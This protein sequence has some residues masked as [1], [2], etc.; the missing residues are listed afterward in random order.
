MAKLVPQPQEAVAL[1]F[2][3]LKDGAH[4]VVDEI[5]FAIP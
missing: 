5:E 2:S 4:Q 1:G 3:I